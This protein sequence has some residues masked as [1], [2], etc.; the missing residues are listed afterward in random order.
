M[1]YFLFLLCPVLA[2]AQGADVP[3]VVVDG[4]VV[5]SQTKRAVSGAAV[6]FALGQ[7]ASLLAVSDGQ[8]RFRFDEA[9]PALTA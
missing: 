3:R 6:R 8:G 5:D 4:R 9:A 7:D 1:K 2:A